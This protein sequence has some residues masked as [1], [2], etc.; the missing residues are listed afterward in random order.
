MSSIDK[1]QERA[2]YLKKFRSEN[3]STRSVADEPLSSQQIANPDF[4]GSPFEPGS[5]LPTVSSDTKLGQPI[6]S[7]RFI[8]PRYPV[9]R[10]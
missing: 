7:G 9:Y 8:D 2:E 6:P 3:Y 1:E 5:Y 10:I 4:G